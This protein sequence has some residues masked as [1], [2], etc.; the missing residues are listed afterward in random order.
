M[1]T[2]N[3]SRKRII[4]LDLIPLINIV[5]L[6][7]IFFML[8]SS[9]ISSSFKAELPEAKT[10]TKIIN[11]NIILKI[12][13]SGLL[14]LNGKKIEQGQ[15]QVRLRDELA[16]RETKTIEVR[17]DKNAEFE[18][19]GEIIGLARNAGIEDFIFATQEQQ[20]IRVD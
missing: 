2:I 13:E 5:F 15:L 16:E 17:G 4:E 3:P 7:L 18:S 11:K 1:I 20:S 8:T 9:S 19:F 6:L 14:E 12:S 10:H